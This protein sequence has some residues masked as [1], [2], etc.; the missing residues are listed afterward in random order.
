MINKVNFG[1]R[2]KQLRERKRLSQIELANILEVSNGSIIKWERNERQPD[3]ETLEKIADFFNT[4]IDYLLGRSETKDN[5][6]VDFS[7]STPQEALSFILKQDMVADF[8]GF[9]LDNMSD[10]EIMEMADDIA[11]MLKIISRKHK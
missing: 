5:N 7:F 10:D 11:D 6:N 3:Y 4:S 1:L 8:G 9:D 2:L